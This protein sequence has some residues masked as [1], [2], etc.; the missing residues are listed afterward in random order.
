LTIALGL[1]YGYPLQGSNGAVNCTIFGIF[2]EPFTPGNAH[3]DKDVVLNVDLGLV[4]ANDSDNSSI[5]AAYILMDGND[6][7]YNNRPEYTRDL[8]PGRWLIG[9][10]VPKETIAKSLMVDPSSD[11]LGGEQFTIPFVETANA[12]NGKVSLHYYGIVGSKVESNRKSIEFDIGIL[13]NDTSRLLLSWK[14]FSLIDQWGWKYGSKAY[15]KY[16][17]E[18]FPTVELQPNETLR[19]RLLFN[20]ISPLSR[21]V[22]LAYEYNN[23]SAIVIDIDPEGGLRSSATQESGACC[24]QPQAEAA[25]TTLAGSI[26]ATKARLAKVRENLNS[27]A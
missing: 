21:P 8:Q 14:N 6:W 2:K 18:G 5:E 9:F 24:S 1:A 3:A 11:P 4:R 17:R 25:P 15:N 27:S 26:K 22:S 7:V 12:S 16:S 23:T 10:V 19:S 20:S 13:N